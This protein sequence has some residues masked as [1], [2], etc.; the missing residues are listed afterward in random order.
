V[1]DN[2][3]ATS[4]VVVNAFTELGLDTV[5]GDRRAWVNVSR[6]FVVSAMTYAL[7]KERVVLEL[8]EDQ[9][10]DDELLAQLDLL[11]R[12]GYTVAL[13][14]FTWAPEREPLLAHVD[15][16][17]VE[18][19]GRDPEAVAEDVERL[20]PYG[21]T[22]LAEKLETREDYERCAAL[23]FE[24]FQGYFFCKPETLSARGV[25]PNRLSMLQLVAALQDPTVEFDQLETLIGR[26][27]ALSYR[28]LRYINSAFF[29]LRREC[30]S[31]G[32]ALT[33]LGLENV[34]RWS[35]LT[36]F[37][38]I[39]DKPR[40]VIVTGL[41]RARF[42]ELA[43]PRHFGEAEPA[44]LFTLGLFSVIDAMMDAPMDEVLAK[45]PFPAE[46]NDALVSRSGPKGEL[47]EAALRC[48]RGDFPNA[49]LAQIQL[50][51]IAWATEA[52]EDL[53]ETPA[54]AAA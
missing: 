14:D 26:D 42:C 38:G 47:L 16:V 50:D 2:D 36:N 5:V 23:G 52:A 19:L 12:E 1:G 35:T 21:V 43:G 24:L 53:F 10:A 6:E 7:P 48:E 28:L 3:E 40:E 18:V 34:K 49:G 30:E 29:G 27:V 45:M 9:G 17:K 51:A 46:M 25:A 41:T 13:D 33:L 39:D 11:R 8:L 37:A 22:L 31:I 54:A 15:I 44:Q 20:R 32:R 4:T